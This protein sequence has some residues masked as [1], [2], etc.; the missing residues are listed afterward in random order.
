M[1]IFY[2]Y[3]EREVV[4]DTQLNNVIPSAHKKTRRKLALQARHIQAGPIF[5][6]FVRSIGFVLRTAHYCCIK[7]TATKKKRNTNYH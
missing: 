5:E 2:S 6:Y 1:I 7:Q 3:A 4:D